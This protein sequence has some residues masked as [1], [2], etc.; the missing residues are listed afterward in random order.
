MKALITAGILA[1]LAV[2]TIGQAQ[3]YEWRSEIELCQYRGDFDDNKYTAKQIENSHFVL[4]S[5]T[6]ANLE[7]FSEPMS[8]N[9]LDNISSKDPEVLTKEYK[10]AK[11]HVERL[12]IVPEAQTYKQELLKTIDGEYKTAQLAILAYRNPSKALKQSPPM[13]Q[14]YVEA[15]LQDETAVQ[16]KWRQ[17]VEENIQ[18]KVRTGSLSD[19]FYRKIEMRDYQ[20]QK[21][22]S[23]YF[24]ARNAIVSSGFYNCVKSTAYRPE[25]KTVSAN[26]AKLNHKIFDG[27]YT[28]QCV[29][30]KPLAK[31]KNIDHQR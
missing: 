23:A 13:C 25:L 27:K 22:L 6:R 19:E 4:N 20:Q 30:I 28:G 16:N 21:S 7:S 10:Q 29:A 2:T 5:L 31:V 1:S 15:L 17:V 24:Y 3:T 8:N 14:H 9:F 11:R 26:Y 12:D 18:D